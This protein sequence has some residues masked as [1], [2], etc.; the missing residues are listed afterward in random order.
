MFE[1][2][3]ASQIATSEEDEGEFY[4]PIA[5]KDAAAAHSDD[6]IE[7][8]HVKPFIDILPPDSSQA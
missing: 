7:E 5:D 3:Q 4:K 2:E 6:I 8:K 1:P